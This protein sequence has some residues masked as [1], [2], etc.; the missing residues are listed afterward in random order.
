MAVIHPLLNKEKQERAK[1]YEKENRLLG[2]ADALLALIILLVFYYSGA[3]GRLA[4]L[5]P[6]R[7]IILVFLV[8]AAIFL[9]GLILLTLPLAFYSDYIHEHKWG[10]SNQTVKAWLK[11]KAKSFLVSLVLGL[12]LLG[13]F[14]WVLALSP[15]FWWLV[16]G[17][18]MAVV[19]TL[20][21]TLLPV[22]ILPLF[23]KYTP[24]EDKELAG[25]LDKILSRG[26][27]RSSGFFK[28]DMSRQTKKENAFLAGLGRTR[29]VVLADNLIGH[30]SV[31]EIVSIIAHEVGHY[32]HKHIWKNIFIG[33]AQQIIVFFLLD[34]ILGGIFP[35]FLSSTR[36][37]LE[38]FP[39]FVICMGALSGLLFGPLS[40]ALSRRYERQAD[41][42][43]LQNTEDRRAFLTALA[44]LADRNLSNAYPAWWVKL[45]Y[46]SHPPI[47]ERLARAEEFTPQR[48][49]AWPSGA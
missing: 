43:A 37:N 6:G 1:R 38:H 34:R 42:Y 40:L 27:L 13:L 7:P 19:S 24:I 39:L 3:S 47:G 35:G 45:I 11:D 48:R 5:F 25:A 44:G 49:A 14:F 20:F 8:Y 30:M 18:A 9:S 16:A 17:L 22:V 29:R 15:K 32:R 4:S 12:V 21:A 36:W 23:N 33:T 31:A 41:N 10:F 28:E 2:L 26:G 46:Y